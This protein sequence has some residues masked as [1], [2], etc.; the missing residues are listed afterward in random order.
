MVVSLLAD[1]ECSYIEDAD[2]MDLDF[3]DDRSL[4]LYFCG[5]EHVCRKFNNPE[6]LQL[7]KVNVEKHYPVVG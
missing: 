5:H 3:V 1:P 2:L 4:V 6:A 7:A